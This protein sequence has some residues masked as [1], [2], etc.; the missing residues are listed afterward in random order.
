M[1]DACPRSFAVPVSP[2]AKKRVTAAGMDL[3]GS[4]RGPFLGTGEDFSA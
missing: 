1:I 4:H 3:A 2:V